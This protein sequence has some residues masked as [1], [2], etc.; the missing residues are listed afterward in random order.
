MNEISL[1]LRNIR[2]FLGKYVC[3]NKSMGLLEILIIVIILGWLLGFSLSFGGALIHILLV[4]A[5]LLIVLRLLKG[6]SL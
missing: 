5:V 6:E 1:G 2:E 3:Y 4:V